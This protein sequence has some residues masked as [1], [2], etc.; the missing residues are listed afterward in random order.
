MSTYGKHT[1][2]FLE[3][4]FSV[5]RSCE[6]YGEISAPTYKLRLNGIALD[7]TVERSKLWRRPRYGYWRTPWFLV[8]VDAHFRFLREEY[9]EGDYPEGAPRWA[10][11]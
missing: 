8:H 5:E 9:I 1:S 11:S 4:A 6:D 2:Q 3:I 10:T 7:V